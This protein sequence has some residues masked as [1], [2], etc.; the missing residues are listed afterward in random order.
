MSLNPI[1]LS[2]PAPPPLPLTHREERKIMM[3]FHLIV[4]CRWLFKKKKNLYPSHNTWQQ[5]KLTAEVY[6]RGPCTDYFQKQHE[7]VLS[8]SFALWCVIPAASV[9]ANSL[10]TQ[11]RER[12]K[13]NTAVGERHEIS[14]F[15]EALN[16]WVCVTTERNHSWHLKSWHYVLLLQSDRDF[17]ECL[18]LISKNLFSFLIPNN[19]EENKRGDK[20]SK[21]GR[22]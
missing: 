5:K 21:V 14:D 13:L 16:K 6:H 3:I 9:Y 17:R 11:Y 8:S 15:D 4:K 19:G 2:V 20:M 12:H 22:K 10:I 1:S 7:W 18:Q